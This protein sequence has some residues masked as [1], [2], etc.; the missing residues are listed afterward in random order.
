MQR[1]AREIGIWRTLSHTHILPLLGVFWGSGEL[2]GMVSPLCKHGNVVSYLAR[3]PTKDPDERLETRL[4]LVSDPL[5][6]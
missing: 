4:R 5:A 6:V 1:I 3:V 2:P